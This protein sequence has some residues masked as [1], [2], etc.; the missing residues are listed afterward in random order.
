MLDQ[1]EEHHFL[2]RLVEDNIEILALRPILATVVLFS[3]SGRGGKR[4]WFA[5]TTGQILSCLEDI[6]ANLDS[7]PTTYHEKQWRGLFCEHLCDD[8]AR[9]LGAT[10]TLPLFEII[11]KTI[12]FANGSG[13]RVFKV[14]DLAPTS[15]DRAIMS[16]SSE[17][18]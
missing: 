10:Q 18:K 14:I 15:L 6:Q 9:T 7:F 16:L 2:D 1:S 17:K 3:N 12:H 8:V 4:N 13:T 5:I 11:A